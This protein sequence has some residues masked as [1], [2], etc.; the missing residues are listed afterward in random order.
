MKK[1]LLAIGSLILLLPTLEAQDYYRV[2]KQTRISTGGLDEA[3]AVPYLDGGVVYI[4][5]STSVGASSP[6]DPEGRRL[7]T[8]FLM[9]KGGQKRPFVDALV[10]QRHDGPVSFT[11]DFKTMVFSQQR[12]SG[13]N[14]DFDPLG[15]YFAENVDGNWVNIRPFEYNDDFAWLFSPAL[16]PDGRTLFFSAD[17]PDGQGGFDIYRSTLK[18]DSWT[19]PENLGTGVNTSGNEIYPFYHASG[20]LFFSSDGHDNNVGGFD[21]YETNL[22]DGQ[23]TRAIKLL[24]PFNSLSDD[25]QIWFSE[26]FKSGYLTSNRQSASKEIF[27]FYTDIP[28]FESPEPIKKTYYTYKIYDRKL[29]TV[30]T[31]LFRYSWVINDTLEIPGHEIIYRFPKP[32]TYVCRL[33]VF[34]IQLDTLVEG[35]TV[36]TLNINLNEQAVI[37]CPDTIRANTT[38]EFDGSQTY[39]PGFNVGRYVWDFGDGG[40]A[41][42]ITVQHTFNYPGTYRVILGVEERRR[43]RR[44]EPEV[45]SNYKDVTVVGR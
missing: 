3:A 28:T 39:L 36:K 42:G 40:F 13:V 8:I 11:A 24:A 16:S 4:T 7:F 18:G 2:R 45:R 9:E 19:R 37:T 6:T 30:D 23:W 26:D 27:T 12:P 1:L 10:T 41:Q 5:E 25:Y 21:L 31:N 34:D 32:G 43:N 33:K 29:D 14:R 22:V 44:Q 20:K 35:Q 17:F 15:L 38:T